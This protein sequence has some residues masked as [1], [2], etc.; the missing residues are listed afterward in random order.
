MVIYLEKHRY[1]PAY[2]CFSF[3]L[4]FLFSFSLLILPKCS[5][6]QVYGGMEMLPPPGTMVPMTP[7]YMPAIIKGMTVDLQNPLHFD[8]FVSTGDSHLRGAR[9]EKEARKLV[10]YFL[11]T[12][13]TP[14]RDLWVNLSPYERNR[15]IT[16]A[17]GVTE[18]GRDLLAH[19]NSYLSGRE[20][21]ENFLGQSICQSPSHIRENGYP[22]RYIQQS[23]DRSGQST[24]FRAGE[25]GCRRENAFESDVGRRLCRL[26][27]IVLRR[28]ERDQW[29]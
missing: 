16:E 4:S 12:L 7:P 21:R 5:F 9:F 19:R 17:F 1:C 11:A 22:G 14:D 6:A 18:M 10:K 20:S 27:K 26:A 8:F 3:L 25:Y 2:R 13:T 24:G 23:L 15:I 28:F 29:L